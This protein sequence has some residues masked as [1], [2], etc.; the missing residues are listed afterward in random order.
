MLMLALLLA[1]EDIPAF[2]P[3]VA[4]TLC[5]EEA[6]SDRI[7]TTGRPQP[8]PEPDLAE[9]VGRRAAEYRRFTLSIAAQDAGMAASMRTCIRTCI[10]TWTKPEGIDWTMV[11]YCADM[12]LDGKR[13]FAL[14]RR[15]APRVLVRSL[16]RCRGTRGAGGVV[17][18]DGVAFCARHE[19]IAYRNFGVLR[20]SVRDPAIRRAIDACREEN[21]MGGAIHWGLALNCAGK[22]ELPTWFQPAAATVQSPAPP[23]Q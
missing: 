15:G 23:G 6:E 12:M 1:V 20:A 22:V 13:D 8:R 5:G 17:A 11:A 16:D 14:F 4:L 7:V 18:W 3:A 2:D 10:R 19:V 9:C 21:T